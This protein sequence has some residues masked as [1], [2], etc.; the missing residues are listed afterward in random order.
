MNGALS[1]LRA[2]WRGGANVASSAL[3]VRP[4]GAY[5]MVLAVFAASCYI[6]LGGNGG[7]GARVALPG[8]GGWRGGAVG[9]DEKAGGADL[10]AAYRE[11]GTARGGF[12]AT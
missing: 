10:G 6:A 5:F 4:G 9:A 3:L 8:W 2:D 7:W 11:V 1:L 12:Q